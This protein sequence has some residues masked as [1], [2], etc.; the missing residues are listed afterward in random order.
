L[1]KGNEQVRNGDPK[2]GLIFN[3]GMLFKIANKFIPDS[4]KLETNPDRELRLINT[5]VSLLPKYKIRTTRREYHR[6]K[7]VEDILKQA[8]FTV[9]KADLDQFVTEN[10][11]DEDSPITAKSNRIAIKNFTSFTEAEKVKKAGDIA[12]QFLSFLDNKDNRNVIQLKSAITVAI[13]AGNANKLELSSENQ[14]KQARH[15]L[16]PYLNG[17]YAVIES[18]SELDSLGIILL[19]NTSSGQIIPIAITAN[20]FLSKYDN[21]YTYLDAEYFKVFAVLNEMYDDLKLNLNKI[22]DIVILDVDQGVSKQRNIREAFSDFQEVAAKQNYQI[23]INKDSDL[24]EF[25]DVVFKAINGVLR[26]YDSEEKE[27]V[28]NLFANIRGNMLDAPLEDL[29]AAEKGLRELFG[30][31]E[32]TFNSAVDFKRPAEYLYAL[33]KSLILTRYGIVPEG[34]VTGLRDYAIKYQDFFGVLKA[35]YSDNLDEYNKEQEKILGIIGGLK[36][37]TPDKI[38]SKDLFTINGIITGSISLMRHEIDKLGSQVHG[39]TTEY[40]ADIHYTQLE[41]Q[42]IGDYRKHFNPL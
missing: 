26:T 8:Y 2:A 33:V 42:M 16:Q 37:T 31:G 11:L 23:R 6:E 40:Y 38:A 25:K 22:Q 36:T 5:L 41:Q 4:I 39:D 13:N 17:Q 24:P 32:K 34:D 27:S 7:L 20:N 15:A 9:N 21:K 29:R 14:Q 18:V 1:T 35:F 19:R 12:D 3:D 10:P 30:L 28:Y